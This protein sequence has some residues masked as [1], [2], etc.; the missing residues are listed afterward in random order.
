M[1]AIDAT[2]GVSNAEGLRYYCAK[3]FLSS[4]RPDGAISKVHV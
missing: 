3:V 2:I 4:R 1:D